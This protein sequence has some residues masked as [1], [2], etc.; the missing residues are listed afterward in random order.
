MLDEPSTN[1]FAPSS[2][3]RRPPIRIIA[4]NNMYACF[5]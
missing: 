5:C 1:Q 2:M 3:S 4:C